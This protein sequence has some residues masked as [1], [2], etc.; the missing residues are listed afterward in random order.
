MM[1]YDVTHKKST[2]PNQNNFLIANYKTC[3]VFSAFEQL[4]SAYHTR[5]IPVQNHV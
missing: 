1:E 4:S 3:Q 5:D 2:I